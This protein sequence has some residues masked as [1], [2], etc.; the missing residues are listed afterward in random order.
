MELWRWP[1]ILIIGLPYAIFLGITAG[2]LEAVPLVGP[3]L[4]AAPAL[5]IALALDPSKAVW[6]VMATVVIQLT[7]NHFLV[8]RVMDRAVGVNPVVSLLAFAAFSS[9]FG[10]AGALLAIPLAVLIQLLLNRTILEPT[11]LSQPQPVG[12]DSISL[13]RYE[14]QELIKDVH[15]QVRDK[16][17][18]MDG[19]SDRIED[20]IEEVVNDL[21]SIL[22]K[23]ES[24]QQ[25]NN[26]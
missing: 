26:S 4:G 15:K 10:L 2:I 19:S 20:A 16:D 9:L 1:L 13:M 21:D 25:D 6:V 18:A 14:V 3:I 17:G 5:L 24:S 8:P 7:E 12:R 22:A 11:S 23:V